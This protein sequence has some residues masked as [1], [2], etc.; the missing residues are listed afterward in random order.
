MW[1]SFTEADTS[2]EECIVND[3]SGDGPLAISIIHPIHI[4]DL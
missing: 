4:Y 2:V 3:I 1:V